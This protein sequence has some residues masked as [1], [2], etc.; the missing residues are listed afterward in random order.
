M[1]STTR[2]PSM[3][4]CAPR[5]RKVMRRLVRMA[6]A[7]VSR[8]SAV[9]PA[10]R[11]A[12]NGLPLTLVAGRIRGAKAALTKVPLE[13]RI[14]LPHQLESVRLAVVGAH[15]PHLVAQTEPKCLQGACRCHGW[16]VYRGQGNSCRADETRWGL[17]TCSRD[18]YPA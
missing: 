3:T 14:R 6:G 1:G 7:T 4:S 13:F 12:L 15:R 9:G 5:W 10:L 8:I 16:G 2:A 18:S 17:R 11:G